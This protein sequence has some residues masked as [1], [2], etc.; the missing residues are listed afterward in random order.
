MGTRYR[1]SEVRIGGRRLAYR[2]W[3]GSAPGGP[4][5]LLHGLLDSAEGWNVTMRACPQ[6]AYAFDL[7]GFGRSDLPEHATIEALADDVLAAIRVL[8]LRRFRL[9]GHSMGG[10]TAALIAARA[11]A[12]IDDLTLIAPA[13]FGP[14]PLAAIADRSVGQLATN[15]VPLVLSSKRLT[16]MIYALA[17]ANGCRP[18]PQLAER[19]RARATSCLPGLK[20]GVR[21]VA[22]ISSDGGRL[23]EL[24][25]DY[26][27]PVYALWGRRDQLVPASHADGV[28]EAFPQAEVHV[29]ERV[30]HHPQHERP[31]LAASLLLEPLAAAAA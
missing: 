22:R 5:V 27:G 14:L 12:A 25:H 21:A 9:I 10:A 19:L 16:A 11:P 15:L 6:E 17:V 23:R 3:P 26:Q 2:H 28:L 4:L 8:G 29:W 13:G 30:G 18:D 31:Q 1:D 24:E 7:P 20:M